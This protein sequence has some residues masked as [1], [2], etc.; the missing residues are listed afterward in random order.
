MTNLAT[1]WKTVG[2]LT[3]KP[4]GV[5]APTEVK[6]QQIYVVVGFGVNN[7][8]AYQGGTAYL[9]VDPGHAFLYTVR[10]NKVTR[11]FSFGP[12]VHGEFLNTAG[13]PDYGMDYPTRLFKVPVSAEEMN[14]VEAKVDVYRKQIIDGSMPYRGITND[15]CAETVRQILTESGVNTPN[16]TGPVSASKQL[17]LRPN[18]SGGQLPQVKS[19][20]GSFTIPSV[21][22]GQWK[23]Q[24]QKV[25][26][27][28]PTLE[29]GKLPD[30]SL[31]EVTVSAPAINAVNPYKWYDEFKKSKKY[32]EVGLGAKK[33]YWSQFDRRDQL[34]P[35]AGAWEK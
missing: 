27:E 15:T 1:I 2:Q 3:T 13:T 12:R 29:G 22:V 18:L 34:D 30:A 26:Y 8:T 14:K 19:N 23:T 31:E 5:L 25:G 4:K 11:F 7:P 21:G 10:N 32:A 35:A 33:D 6:A 20:P 16:G 28:Y 9:T 24:A 17:P